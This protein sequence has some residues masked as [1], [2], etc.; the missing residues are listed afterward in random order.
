MSKPFE[1]GPV[2]IRFETQPDFPVV[3]LSDSN[4]EML[5]TYIL[6]QAGGVEQYARDLHPHHQGLAY[7]ALTYKGKSEG[8]T[9]PPD[10]AEAFSRGFAAFE[11]VS[12]AVHPRVY[13]GSLAVHQAH[14]TLVTGGYFTDMELADRSDA[15]M[16]A[17]PNVV[18]LMSRVSLL[19]AETAGQL[20]ARLIGAQVACEL[21]LPLVA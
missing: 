2:L 4:T 15:W 9:L 21:Q 13:D 1:E 18:D 20:S 3:D 14:L 17:R 5:A 7:L 19:R 16:D 6:P 8:Y 10:E 12:M 11:Y